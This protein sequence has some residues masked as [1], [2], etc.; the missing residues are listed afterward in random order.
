MHLTI[1]R[2]LKKLLNTRNIMNSKVVGQ[3]TILSWHFING[4]KLES[5]SGETGSMPSEERV[6]NKLGC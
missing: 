3:Q 4:E 6:M 2:H 1:W 5:S